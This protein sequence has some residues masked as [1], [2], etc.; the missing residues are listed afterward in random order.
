MVAWPAGNISG[1]ATTSRG[2]TIYEATRHS[3]M[4]LFIRAQEVAACVGLQRIA[5]LHFLRR[6]LR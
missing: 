5:A 1:E 2:N 6:P 4:N 3:T